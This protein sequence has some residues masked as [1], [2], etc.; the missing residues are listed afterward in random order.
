MLVQ[1]ANAIGWASPV[2]IVMAIGA[3]ALFAAFV[4]TEFRLRDPLIAPAL[5]RN[6]MFVG[7]TVVAL[8]FGAA[9]F[10]PLVFI[11]L[12]LL[13][14]VG[15][16][17]I[18]AGLQIAPFALA[19]LAVSLLAARVAARLGVR[20]ALSGGLALCGGG[21]AMMLLVGPE[22]A[23]LRLLPGWSCSESGPASSTRRHRRP[24]VR[25]A[26]SAGRRG[27]SRAGRARC[28]GRRRAA[29]RGWRCRRRCHVAGSRQRGLRSGV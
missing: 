8:V 24:R 9:G 3:V 7:A 29:G 21:V 14:V 6:S 15:S 19:S 22:D 1:R 23:G 20:V 25:P 10:A 4:A 11:S 28:L 13:Q 18:L 12:F 16:D 27:G 17:P 5:M 2:T 26:G